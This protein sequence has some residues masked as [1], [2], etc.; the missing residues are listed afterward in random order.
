MVVGCQDE[1]RLISVDDFG[2]EVDIAE[3]EVVDYGGACG[4]LV[5]LT[6]SLS[7]QGRG[8]FLSSLPLREGAR[9]GKKP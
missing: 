4:P 2:T 9:G 1:K 7:R 3:V 6:L 8:K 5:T